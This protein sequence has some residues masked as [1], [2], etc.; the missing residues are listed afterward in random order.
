MPGGTQAY[1]P[2]G[3]L[4]GGA[5]GDQD[6]DQDAQDSF[7]EDS[8]DTDDDAPAQDSVECVENRPEA[9]AVLQEAGSKQKVTAEPLTVEESAAE[10][11]EPQTAPESVPEP[12]QE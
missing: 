11:P 5:L 2:L 4:I 8:F 6:V 1:K 7:D 10:A 12:A 3:E 9:L